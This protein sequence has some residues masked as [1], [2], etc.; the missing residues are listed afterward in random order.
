MVMALVVIGLATFFYGT[1]SEG[2]GMSAAKR[3]GLGF[4]MPAVIAVLGLWMSY[5]ACGQQPPALASAHSTGGLLWQQWNPGKV[6]HSLANN[7]K[8]IWVDY[9]ADW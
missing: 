6:E 7:K 2:H 3:V 1:W 4:L 5:D 9:T 8:I